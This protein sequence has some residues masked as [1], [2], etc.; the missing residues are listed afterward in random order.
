[1][2]SSLAAM[3]QTSDYWSDADLD[4]VIH[5]L[6]RNKRLNVPEEVKTVLGLA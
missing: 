3:S 4:S 5:Y 1:M 2:S 6:R